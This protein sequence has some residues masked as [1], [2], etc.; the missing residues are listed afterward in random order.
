VE[1]EGVISR[2]RVGLRLPALVFAL[3]LA[4]RIPYLVALA[5]TPFLEH[6]LLDP[7]LYDLWAQR[8]AGGDWLG[9]DAFYANPLY[10]YYLGLVYATIGRHLV[11]VHLIQHLL[12]SLGAALLA[13]IGARLFDRRVGLVAGCGAALYAPFVFHEGGL[14]IEALAPF[15]G[16]LALFLI[17]RAGERRTLPA[18]LLAGI[19][20]G[21]FVLARPN[22]TPLAAAVWAFARPA[23]DPAGDPAG[24]R[25]RRVLALLLGAGL[26]ILPVTARNF[27]LSGR[28]VLITA[29]G[30]ETFY[31][32]NH[33]GSDGYGTQPDWVDTGPATEHESYRR[34]ASAILGREVTLAE[35]SAYWRDQALAFARAEPLAYARLLARKAYLFFHGYEK[36]DNASYYFMRAEVPYLRLLP[37]SFGI[38]VPLAALGL[39]VTRRDWARMGIVPL[40]AATYALGVISYFVLARYRLAVVPALLLLAGAGAGWWWDA[41]RARRYAPAGAAL[42]GVVAIAAVTHIST[43]AVVKDDPATTHNNYGLVLEEAGLLDQAAAQYAAAST[44]VPGRALYRANLAQVELRR[45]RT[46]EARALLAAAV[47]LEPDFADAHADLGFLAEAEGQFDEALHE[48]TRAVELDPSLVGPALNAAVLLERAGRITE[49]E[50]MY[51]RAL[52]ANPAGYRENVGLALFLVRG[53]RRCEAIPLLAAARPAAPSATTA[54]RLDSLAADF[55]RTCAG[56][57]PPSR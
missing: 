20:S 37:L 41:L 47:R 57:A 10:P 26:A 44:L 42:A 33:A 48:Y 29:H 55:G 1:P 54:A 27:A 7:R 56:A 49:A 19:A 21:I 31:V 22:L 53:G 16:V 2:A 40:F 3:A 35:S 28:F 25:G 18:W 50:P 8:L 24:A 23:G 14:M 5:R 46:A 13:V 34:R 36:G 38:V 11:L 17:V 4:A 9:R 39:W 30:G 12:G 51:R 52:A 15:L 6:P 45:G 32:G 43:P